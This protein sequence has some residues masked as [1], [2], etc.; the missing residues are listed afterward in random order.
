V[1]DTKVPY[2]SSLA[3][4]RKLLEAS[5]DLTDLVEAAKVAKL[6]ARFRGYYAAA[7][8]ILGLAE[9]RRGKLILS[10]LGHQLLATEPRSLGEASVFRTAIEG[11]KPIMKVVP[12]L[13]AANGPTAEQVISLLKTKARMAPSTAKQRGDALMRWRAHVLGGETQMTITSSLANAAAARYDGRAM[14]RAL[15]IRSLKAFGDPAKGTK[16]AR[17]ETP[18][19]TVLV[20]PNGAG[21]STILQALDIL[22]SLVRGNINQLLDAHGW[23]YADLPHLLSSKQTITLEVEVEVGGSVIEWSLTLGTRRR[24]G[25]AAERVRARG[26]ADVDWR[27]LLERDGRRVKLLRESTGGPISPPPMTLTQSWLGTLDASAKED[28]ASFPGLLA[29]KAWA[30]RIRPFWSLD[31]ALLRSPSRTPA[32]HVGPR[33]GDLATFLFRL[34]R[35]DKKRFAAFVKRVARHYPRL[36]T[37]E[38]KGSN[39]GWKHLTITERWNGEQASFNAKQV[40]DGLLR[41]LAVASIPDWEEVP[42]LVLLDEVENGLHPRLIGGIASLLQEISAST[43]VIATTH[44]PITLNYIPAASTRLVTRGKSGSVQITPLTETKGFD[45]LRA[46]FEPGEL[47]YNVGEERLVTPKPSRR[48]R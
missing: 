39:Y 19:L 21:K 14:L 20:G 48:A 45:E 38:S 32:T 6:E 25:V 2:A 28:V 5:R 40:S 11:A 36:V 3:K 44:S 27:T 4:L 23:D 13:L 7:S 31:P 29:L 34:E 10:P 33:G 9:R 43:Q 12:S 1:A 26:V 30:E 8:E 16:P 22:G 15:Q 18:P 41:L 17:I 47:W 42:S 35:R 46:H 37:N 24:A